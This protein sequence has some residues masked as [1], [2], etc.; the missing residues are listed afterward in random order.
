MVTSAALL[1]RERGVAGTSVTKVLE[2]SGGPRGSVGFHFPGG[3]AELLVDAV[4][5]V[6]DRITGRIRSTQ[7]ARDTFAGI[8]AHYRKQLIDTDFT[9]GCPIGA[10]A[11][12]AYADP[13]LG[14]VVA[15]IVSDWLT[16]LTESLE[17]DGHP[18]ADAE[19]LAVLCVSA[20]EGAITLARVRR[21]TAPLDAVGARISPLLGGAPA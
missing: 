14:P 6:G 10:T 5:T 17:R 15:G 18:A 2:H 3:R 21:S 20:M 16:A 9:A 4:R 13:A 7:N 11:Q 12:E 8:V 19:E 1:L